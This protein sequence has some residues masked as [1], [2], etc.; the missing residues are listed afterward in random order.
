[1]HFL[2]RNSVSL[3]SGLQRIFVIEFL[4]KKLFYHPLLVF[5]WSSVVAMWGC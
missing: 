2:T 5:A 1:M 4:L 3:L